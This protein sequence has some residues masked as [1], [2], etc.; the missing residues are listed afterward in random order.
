MGLW[1]AGPGKEA[2]HLAKRN[3]WNVKAGLGVASGSALGHWTHQVHLWGGV[4][5]GEAENRC[6]KV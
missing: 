5:A 1:Q 3:E 4:W 6:P 2:E